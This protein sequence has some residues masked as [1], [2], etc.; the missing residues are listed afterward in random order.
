VVILRLIH[1]NKLNPVDL[2]GGRGVGL[3]VPSGGPSPAPRPNPNPGWLAGGCALLIGLGLYMKNARLDLH[4]LGC[5]ALP[6][7]LGI[8][9]PGEWAMAGFLGGQVRRLLTYQLECGKM[10]CCG[11]N[12]YR[13]SGFEPGEWA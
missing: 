10:G 7:A 5:P 4:R 8:L 6:A 1:G 12:G 2:Q 13:G 3:G 9:P 11:G